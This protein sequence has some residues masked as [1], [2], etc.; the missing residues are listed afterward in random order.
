MDYE[1]CGYVTL[2]MFYFKLSSY[3]NNNEK[4]GMNTKLQVLIIIIT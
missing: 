2:T 1:C 4:V 3:T